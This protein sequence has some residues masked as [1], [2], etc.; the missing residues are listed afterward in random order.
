VLSAIRSH[1]AET[2]MEAARSGATGFKTGI[3]GS[4][5]FPLLPF[6]RVFQ[7]VIGI[8]PE[9][10]DALRHSLGSRAWRLGTLA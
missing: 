6:P 9:L 3:Y 4:R 7:T 5:L 8:R 1:S 2:L 10:E